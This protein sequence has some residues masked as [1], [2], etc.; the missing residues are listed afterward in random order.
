MKYRVLLKFLRILIY[1]KRFFWWIGSG[2]FWVLGKGIGFLT[3]GLF[4]LKLKAAFFLKRIGVAQSW[5]WL[6]KRDFLQIVVFLSLFFTTIG[7]SKVLAKVDLSYSG[8]KTL[9]YT[10]IGADE[11]LVIEEV[12]AD[13]KALSGEN[14]SWKIGSINISETP[15]TPIGEQDLATTVAGGTA[16]SK[17]ILMPGVNLSGTRTQMVDYIVEAGDSLGKI[18]YEFGVSIPT[19][20]WENNL[21]LNSIIRPGNVLKIPPTTGIMHIVKKGDTLSKIASLYQA[22]NLEIIKFNNLNETGADL[23]VGEKIMVPGGVR[24]TQSIAVS[25]TTAI[26]TAVPSR[27]LSLPSLSG[28]VWPAAVRLITQY[29]GFRHHA[30]DIA[31]GNKLT[32]I[33]ATKAGVVEVSQCGWNS[34][35]GCYIIINHGNGVKS[36]Y[37]HNSKLLVSAGDYVETG[38]T[39]SLMGNTGK[40]RGV[41][42]IHLHFEILINGGR[43]NPLGYVK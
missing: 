33:Y 6:F 15:G 30:L 36:L 2:L 17:P 19:I 43:V 25:K 16:I 42:G 20:M 26:R 7:Q 4:Y 12:V 34:G 14:Y 11:E 31:G 13:S 9:A 32:P 35:Y 24:P 1:L 5:D 28:Y 27:S 8:Q 21:T 10:L 40:V 23:K 29:Y 22:E 41:T 18:A 38:Q 39:I 37:G 3:K